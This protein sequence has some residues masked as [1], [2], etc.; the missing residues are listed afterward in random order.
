MHLKFGKISL[1]IALLT[2]LLFAQFG[3]R[4][5]VRYT[6]RQLSKNTDILHQT[7]QRASRNLD[8]RTKERKQSRENSAT[9]NTIVSAINAGLF[10]KTEAMKDRRS[11][12]NNEVYVKI[13]I[14]VKQSDRVTQQYPRSS[15]QFKYAYVNCLKI[16]NDLAIIQRNKLDNDGLT[17]LN[18]EDEKKLVNFIRNAALPRCQST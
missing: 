3:C 5:G 16:N 9:W 8:T 11:K 12:Q 13:Y 10:I 18:S 15:S 6:R 2:A 14:P 17:L 4:S 7:E 1:I